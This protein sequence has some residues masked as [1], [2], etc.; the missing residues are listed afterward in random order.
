MISDEYVKRLFREAWRIQSKHYDYKKPLYTQLFMGKN[1]LD[2]QGQHPCGC[3][4]HLSSFN[5]YNIIP[6]YCFDCYKVVI[7]PRTVVELFK[8]MVVF[9]NLDL[10][11]DNTRKCMVENRERVSGTYK[12][13]IYCRGIEEAR[14][15]ASTVGQTVSTEISEKTPISLKRG[16]SEYTAHYPEYAR[17]NQ[18]GTAMDY[19]EAWREYESLTDQEWADHSPPSVGH[20]HSPRT[21]TAEDALAML[22]WLKYAATIGDK[23]YLKICW[24]LQPFQ[25]VTRPSPFHY[26]EDE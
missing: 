14:E 4:R 12:G 3:K 23:S 20:I 24:S 10:P 5:K 21:Y 22:G 26:V 25:N 6:K 19:K 1:S 17:I 13:L 7:E 11:N 9:E 16:C 2:W 15:I 8:L 18:D